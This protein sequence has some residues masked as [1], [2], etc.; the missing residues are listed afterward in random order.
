MDWGSLDMMN[1]IQ[2]SE[3]FEICYSVFLDYRS[4]LPGLFVLKKRCSE[5]MQQICKRT[6]MAKCDFNKGAKQ[7]Y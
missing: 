2:M 7:L 1:I 6:P 5:N 4:S 3:M